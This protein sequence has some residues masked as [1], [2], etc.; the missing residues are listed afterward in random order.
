M[1][2]LPVSPTVAVVVRP[3]Q[4][5]SIVLPQLTPVQPFEATKARKSDN[6]VLVAVRLPPYRMITIEYVPFLEFIGRSFALAD[7]KSAATIS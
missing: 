2:R 1:G 7:R 4:L 6:L 3:F 5:N